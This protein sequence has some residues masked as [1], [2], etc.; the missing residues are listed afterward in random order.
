MS[1][2]PRSVST[3]SC[4]GAGARSTSS[5]ARCWRALKSELSARGLDLPLYWGNRNWE[6][7]LDAELRRIEAAGHRRVLA[8]MT[9]A[10]PSYSSCRQYRENLFDAA[11][12]TTV[13]DRP[14]PALRRPSGLRR[15][16]G[17]R[18]RAPPW[19]G[20]ARGRRR[21][22]WSSSPIPSPRRWPRRAGPEPRT[23]HRGVRRLAPG[24]RGR[25]DPAGRGPAGQPS[26]GHDL[27]YCSRSGPPSQPWLEPD[28]NDHL[29]ALH[30]DGVAGGGAGARS[31]SSPT[32]WR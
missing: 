21:P 17:R 10:Y 30:A 24:G 7:F 31:A 4:S 1:G 28:V 16:V 13:A 23:A 27:V 2:W 11:A 6:P 25:G 19:T 3:T 15:R 12:G 14:D 5:V 26:Y 9:S 22:G 18:H 29:R 32:T 8:V 20:S